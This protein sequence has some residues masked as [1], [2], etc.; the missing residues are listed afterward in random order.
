MV[1]LKQLNDANK[2]S[3]AEYFLKYGQH[4]QIII[5]QSKRFT[6]S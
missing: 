2:L 6:G 1:N 5:R 4:P 3:E